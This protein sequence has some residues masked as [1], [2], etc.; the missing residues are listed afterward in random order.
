MRFWRIEFA[1]KCPGD[2][3]DKKY[4]YNVRYNYGKEGR[5][6]EYTPYSCIKIISSQPGKVSCMRPP[7]LRP[8][9]GK[10]TWEQLLDLLH[11]VSGGPW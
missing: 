6:S 1:P 11:I 10:P 3:F 5:K 4:A 9:R 8:P 7:C 2:S